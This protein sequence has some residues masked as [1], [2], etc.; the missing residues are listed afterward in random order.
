MKF[1]NGDRALIENTGSADLDDH[2]VIV[3]GL[4]FFDFLSGEAF[5]IIEKA[6][7]SAFDTPN[8]EWNSIVL[9]QHCL[10]YLD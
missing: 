10:T 2:T 6:D 8:G 4:S 1:K 3:T 7:G 9:T 5:Y